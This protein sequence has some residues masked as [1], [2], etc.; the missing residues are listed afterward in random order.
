MRGVVGQVQEERLV[1]VLGDEPLGVVADQVGEVAVFGLERLPVPPVGTTHAVDVGL[2]VDVAADEA[3]ELFET[4]QRRLEPRQV[5]EVPLAEHGGRVAELPEALGDRVGLGIDT[6]VVERAVGVGEQDGGNPGPVLVAP[7]DQPGASRRADR[8][9]GVEVGQH[10]AGGGQPVEVRRL[11][12]AGVRADVAVAEVV[13]HDEDDVRRLPV[14]AARGRV[15]LVWRRSAAGDHSGSHGASECGGANPASC[16][17]C[18]VTT[19]AR[20]FL[21]D[22]GRKRD[23]ILGFNGWQRV[24]GLCPPNSGTHSAG[25][26]RGHKRSGCTGSYTQRRACDPRWRADGRDLRGSGCRRPAVHRRRG[27]RPGRHRDLSEVLGRDA[28]GETGAVDALLLG[29]VNADARLHRRQPGAGQSR[30]A[31]QRT[32]VFLSRLLRTPDRS[33]ARRRDR[34][35]R[36]CA[37]SVPDRSRVSEAKARVVLARGSGFRILERVQVDRGARGRCDDRQRGIRVVRSPRPSGPHAE[38]ASVRHAHAVGHRAPR[39]VYVSL[40]VGSPE[41]LSATGAL[42]RPR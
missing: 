26:L 18:P 5:T 24:S 33:G 6:L 29:P 1:P 21:G 35:Q 9:A 7:G 37:Q 34:Q 22:V 4:V 28:G 3:S 11:D 23:R 38:P 8:A 16:S 2:V 20:R 30:V 36:S 10:H 25:P 39:R 40:R 12:P 42:S 27:E 15:D 41:D 13:G 14:L 31:D 19:A 17:H 32:S